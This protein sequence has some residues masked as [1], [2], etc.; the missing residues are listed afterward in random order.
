MTKTIAIVGAG[1]YGL[2]VAAHL[3]GLPGIEARVFGD[4]MS[5]W[6]DFMPKGMFL[7]S[8]WKAS[9]FSDPES[10]YTL[11][12]YKADTGE[13]FSAPVPL[14][15]FVAY[16]QWFQHHVAPG[17]VT[18]KVKDIASAAEGFLLTLGDNQQVSAD[19]V[20]MATGISTFAWRPPE[21]AALPS[22]FASHSSDH[23][24]F[25]RFCGKHVAIVG[26]G[27]SALE[28]AA[29]LQESGASVDVLVR[30]PEIFWLG[31]K[32]RMNRLG[33]LY[34]LLYSWTDVGPAGI[35]Q[36]VSRPHLFRTLPR[37]VQ[38]PLARRSIRPAGAAWLRPRLRDDQLHSSTT[39]SRAVPNCKEL[40][41]QLND[42][43]E[44]R[45]DHLLLATGYRVDCTRYSFLSQA[46]KSQLKCANGYPVLDT[47]FASSVP[48]LYFVGAP[49]AWSFGPLMR[50]V[51]GTHFTA[52]VLRRH[53]EKAL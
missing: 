10:R 25:T 27:Q 11:D 19:A 21:F 2:S 35:S 33:P 51:A 26:G 24:D 43:S 46:L 36:L 41:L 44:R 34:N 17:L 22:E 48:G 20:V 53:F 1:P 5:F 40:L 4:P 29:L 31:W 9:H 14:E 23:V 32:E 6:R 12:A 38:T 47:D 15:N 45:V 28:S 8:G 49:A 16:G 52:R 50:F 39:V 13:A 3:S 42:G 30:N 37:N 7:R 18:K